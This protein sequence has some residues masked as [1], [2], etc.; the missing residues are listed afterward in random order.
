MTGRCCMILSRWTVEVRFA[1]I[2]RLG[3]GR[4]MF[5]HLRV[6]DEHDCLT[7]PS[8]PSLA[9]GHGMRYSGSARPADGRLPIPVATV[10][11]VEGQTWKAIKV[12]VLTELDFQRAR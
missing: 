8:P 12:S 10:L 6:L 9:P 11:A 2:E 7:H 1:H 4:D 3:S 5:A